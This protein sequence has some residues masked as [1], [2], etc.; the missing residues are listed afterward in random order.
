MDALSETNVLSETETIDIIHTI[1][2]IYRKILLY[3]LTAM[4]EGLK[5]RTRP[6]YGSLRPSAAGGCWSNCPY[7]TKGLEYKDMQVCDDC[8]RQMFCSRVD[9]TP[10]FKP[11][12]LRS[13]N[14]FSLLR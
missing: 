4:C 3:K 13:L 12:M 11:T 14:R 6:D 9:E 5:P 2:Q 1:S 10:C 7:C 8:L